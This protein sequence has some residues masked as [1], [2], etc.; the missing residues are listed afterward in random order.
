MMVRPSARLARNEAVLVVL[1]VALLLQ[2]LRFAVNEVMQAYSGGVLVY[3][4]SI[5]NLMD[6]VA[7]YTG[8]AA[9]VLEWGGSDDSVNEL[10]AVTNLILWIKMLVR[11]RCPQAC[12]SSLP[13]VLMRPPPPRRI[14][15]STLCAGSS[16]RAAS[17]A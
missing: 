12:P 11:A 7:I 14:P 9:I 8:V 2:N 4:L 1:R 10:A 3:V 15:G 5:W 16:T 17:C 13:A 6:T